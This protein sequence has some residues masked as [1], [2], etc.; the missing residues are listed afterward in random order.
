[1]IRAVIGTNIFASGVVGLHRLESVPG[2]IVRCWYRQEF[3][4]VASKPI[5][6]E[7]R[8]T[9][10]NQYFLD[11][12]SSKDREDAME[13][14][15]RDAE[16]AVLTSNIEGAASHPED[17]FILATAVDGRADVLVTGDKQLLRLVSYRG[18]DIIGARDFLTML[19]SPARSDP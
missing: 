14:L 19:E 13:T 18:I 17:D 16:H 2:E 7:V 9:L 11:R 8:R 5:V 1:V 12:S 10:A 4:V 3:I 6:D 15:L